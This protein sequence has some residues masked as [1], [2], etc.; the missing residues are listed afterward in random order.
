MASSLSDIESTVPHK[1]RLLNSCPYAVS[2][3]GDTSLGTT[4][5]VVETVTLVTPDSQSV[6]SSGMP[7]TGEHK[8]SSAETVS[9][10]ILRRMK[11]R[12]TEAPDHLQQL[13]SSACANRSDAERSRITDCEIP[14]HILETDLGLTSLI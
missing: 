9:K 5:S 2:M 13:L 3:N 6:T 11:D 14:R 12:V 7:T 10:F 8:S 1:V 4:E